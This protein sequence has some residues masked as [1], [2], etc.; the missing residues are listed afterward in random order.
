M[1]P[2]ARRLVLVGL[3]VGLTTAAAA[4]DAVTEAEAR[5]VRAVIQ[6]QLDA[7]AVDD[8]ERA[9]AHASPALRQQFGQAERFLAMVRQ[10]YPVVY[11]PAAVRFLKA[12]RVDGELT[13]GVLFTDA[14]GL[15]WPRAIG[16]CSPTVPAKPPSMPSRPG[17]A[18]P[19]R[20]R[21]PPATPPSVERA[22]YWPAA[23]RPPAS[24]AEVP[25][26]PPCRYGRKSRQS[27]VSSKLTG[28]TVAQAARFCLATVSS[29][30]RS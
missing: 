16:R 27:M 22:R 2:P 5:Q 8:A 24:M 3:L 21:P 26:V 17:S 10:H 9:F 25:S 1:R 12:V 23:T 19:R 20:Q 30:V 29:R 6:A 14:K 7:F 15:S 13:Q 18:A 11:R 4:P 28:L